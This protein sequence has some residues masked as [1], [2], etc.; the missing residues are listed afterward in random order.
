MPQWYPGLNAQGY[1]PFPEP[2]LFQQT[3]SFQKGI[4]T[5]TPPTITQPGTA[6]PGTAVTNTT[7][8]DCM[9]YMSATVG[10]GGVSLNPGGTVTAGTVPLLTT[11][12]VYVPNGSAITVNYVNTGALTWHWLA[13]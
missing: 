2:A 9:V 6:G 13:V 4:S 1:K 11:I 10:F 5:A 12:G 8:Y 7:G 3:P